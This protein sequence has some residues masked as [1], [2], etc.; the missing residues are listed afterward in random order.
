M[1]ERI[2]INEVNNNGT[3]IHLYFNGF[4]GLYVAY[5]ISAYLLSKETEVVPSYSEDMQMPAT[6]INVAHYNLLKEKLEVIKKTNNYCCL[7]A[8]ATYDENDYSD[9]ASELRGTK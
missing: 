1:S 4:V 5:G 7:K 9:W 2:V 6:V 8:T 3:E